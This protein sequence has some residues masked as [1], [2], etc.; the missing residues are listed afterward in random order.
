M[1]DELDLEMEALAKEIESR[2]DDESESESNEHKTEASSSDS[3]ETEDVH[4]ESEGEGEDILSSRESA[5]SEAEKS[6]EEKDSSKEKD[7]SEESSE[8][9]DS[10]EKSSSEKKKDE[11]VDHPPLAYSAAAKEQWKKTPK[12]VREAALKREVDSAEGVRL[13]KEKSDYGERLQTQISPYLANIQSRG[14]TPEQ[15]LQFGLNTHHVLS[16]G[17]LSAKTQLIR[18]LAQKAGVDLTQIQPPT[19]IERQLQPYIQRQ[20]QLEQQLAQQNHFATQQRDDGI[21]QAISAFKLE[22][23]EKGNLT[24]PYAKNVEGEMVDMIP[25]MLSRDPGLSHSEV[26]NKAYVKS[27]RTNDDTFQLLQVQQDKENEL[28]RKRKDKEL[29]AKAK[30]AEKVNTSKDGVHD[31]KQSDGLG[32]IDDDMEKLAREIASR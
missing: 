7:S 15:V 13:L 14:A 26:L 28:A 25:G 3:T 29:A 4:G 11:E 20:Q 9:D 10:E 31:S 21:A 32:S 18:T 2:E 23:D 8:K 1:A 12:V 30:K 5:G 19:E 17:D 22:V 27:L 24:H 16:S 6:S